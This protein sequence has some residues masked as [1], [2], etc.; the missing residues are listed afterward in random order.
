MGLA[1]F[2]GAGERGVAE[3]E[4]DGRPVVRQGLGFE[5][6]SVSGGGAGGRV[7]LLA[8]GD[9]VGGIT[10]AGGNEGP[11]AGE[12]LGAAGGGPFVAFAGAA[13]ADAGHDGGRCAAFGAGDHGHH[14]AGAFLAVEGVVIEDE[15]E[16]AGGGFDLGG[17]DLLAVA[18]EGD[19][20]LAVDLEAAG[21]DARIDGDGDIPGAF[22]GDG[23]G[24]HFVPG[25]VDPD[26]AEFRVLVV[27]ILAER[28]AVEDGD[29][30]E[31]ALL[32]RA[33]E[34]G[35]AQRGGG[36]GGEGLDG[37]AFVKSVADGRAQVR[38]EVAPILE[39]GGREG[40]RD[41]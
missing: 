11:E 8:E 26:A 15:A 25:A 20:V 5:R 30:G 34:V 33:H 24:G 35:G 3:R 12:G 9:E 28:G 10:G 7:V 22:E 21:D 40:E 18:V 1:P 23:D 2:D 13:D 6:S 32:E 16:A 29:V 39:S 36:A 31:L 37:D 4:A 17:L 19:A 38:P 14:G 41:A 27:G